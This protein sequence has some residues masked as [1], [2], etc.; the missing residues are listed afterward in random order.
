[1]VFL[2]ILGQRAFTA[3]NVLY[4]FSFPGFLGELAKMTVD[5]ALNRD[6][7]RLA[8]GKLA[9][10]PVDHPLRDDY[11]L[12]IRQLDEQLVCTVTAPA[13]HENAVTG[14]LSQ[15]STAGKRVSVVE[16]CEE[17]DVLEPDRRSCENKRSNA[18][19]NSKDSVEAAVL[20]IDELKFENEILRHMLS[21]YDR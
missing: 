19:V 8:L 6:R 3:T 7:R 18:H 4:M 15:R 1:V 5:F 12:W 9:S 10:I 11:Q 20:R 13:L 17:Q 21:R 14:A 2:P 16:V